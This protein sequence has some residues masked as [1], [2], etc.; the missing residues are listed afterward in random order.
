M[1]LMVKARNCDDDDDDDEDGIVARCDDDGI[2][3]TSKGLCF[4]AL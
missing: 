3:H 1:V 2:P 4:V